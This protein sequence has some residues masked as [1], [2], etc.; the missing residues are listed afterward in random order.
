VLLALLRRRDGFLWVAGIS[1][2]LFR[3]GILHPNALLL[4]A[5][6]RFPILLWQMI[7][8]AGL[9]SGAGFRRYDAMCRKAKAAIM[10]VGWAAFAV[11]FYSDY[12]PDFGWPP[13]NLGVIFNNRPLSL[14]EALRYLSIT[15]G[16]LT[17][18]DLL[19]PLIG[20]NFVASF[21]STLGRRSLFVYVA[22]LFIVTYAGWLCD[23]VFYSAGAWQM[24]ML[25][26]AAG[27]LWLV[28]A[29]SEWITAALARSS[30]RRAPLPEPTGS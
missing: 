11:L 24:L 18:I 20:H 27:L 1:V 19:W 21:L 30:A 15:V 26:P 4:S 10:I 8:I 29:S 17:S 9:L 7:F 12:A 2:V 28:A 6:P 14:G 25:I 22:H 3:I 13:L 16:I 5:N 23:Q